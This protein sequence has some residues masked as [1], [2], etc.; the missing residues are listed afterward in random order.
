[1]SKGYKAGGYNALSA[2]EK[3]NPEYVTTGEIGAKYQDNVTSAS[4]TAFYS[5][6]KDIQENIYLPNAAG[7]PSA[8][9][10]NS[11]RA[12]IYGLE[13]EADRRVTDALRLF[14]NLTLLHARITDASGVDPTFPELGVESFDSHRL[15]RA[16]NVQAVIGAELKLPVVSNLLFVGNGSFRW[17]SKTYLTS[18]MMRPIQWVLLGF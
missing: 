18:T 17:Q 14:G 11:S 16:P 13:T 10:T 8:E 6:Y 1:M 7:V 15:P 2:P 4:V 5:N 9:V 12:K 3:Y